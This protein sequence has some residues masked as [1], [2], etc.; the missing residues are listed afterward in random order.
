MDNSV[1]Q[2]LNEYRARLHWD[3]REYKAALENATEAASKALVKDD[4]TGYWR[5]TFLLAECQMEL[6]LIQEFAASAKELSENAAV[7]GDRALVARSKALYARA[8]E[9]LG[10]IG[11]ALVVAQEAA[12]LDLDEPSD[13]VDEIEMLHGL[14]AALAESGQGCEAWTHA[15]RMAELAGQQEDQLIAGK[16]YWAVGTAAF[17]NDDPDNGVFYH[18]LA[19]ANLAPDND[20]NTWAFFNKSSALARL[21]A[22]IVDHETLECI[23][24]AELANSV[25]GGSPILELEISTARAHWLVLTGEADEAAIRVQQILDQRELLPEHALAEVEYVAALALHELGRNDEALV[26]AVHSEKVFIGHGSRRRALEARS[27]IDSITR[28]N[29]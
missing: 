27:V 12:A 11:E 26:A 29:Q 18:K 16:A 19:A 4:I 22:G 9:T 10:H 21:S 25:T 28:N 20:V 3:R 14:V 2:M 7:Q 1:D 8:L 5:M 15:L 17:L 24:R 23:E 13:T 6:G